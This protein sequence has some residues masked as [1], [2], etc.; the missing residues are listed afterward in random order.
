MPQ[1]KFTGPETMPS[2]RAA[3][4]PTTTTTGTTTA[5]GTTSGSSSYNV[6]RSVYVYVVCAL[7]RK[8]GDGGLE[9]EVGFQIQPAV[10]G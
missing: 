5:T 10:L 8:A 6:P 7:Q 4:W 1:F 9:E 2:G 3:G